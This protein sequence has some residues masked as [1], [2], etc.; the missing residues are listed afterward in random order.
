MPGQEAYDYVIVGADPAGSTL[1]G[2]LSDEKGIKLIVSEA[3]PG[4]RFL[5][6]ASYED[7]NA[8]LIDAG[9]SNAVVS[10]HAPT[11]CLVLSFLTA[12]SHG[13]LTNQCV[14]RHTD[15][16]FQ[17]N[18]FVSPDWLGSEPAALTTHGRVSVS[19]RL[20]DR[21]GTQGPQLYAVDV[22]LATTHSPII[23]IVLSPLGRG[24]DA[25]ALVF[26]LSG[27]LSG[28][29]PSR[30]S[31]SIVANPDGQL[32]IHST[33]SGTLQSS[34]SLPEAGA[35]WKDEGPILQSLTLPHPPGEPA[36]FYRVLSP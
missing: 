12:S 17:T 27:V 15:G 30:P 20:A 28:P 14:I 5:L 34:P 4:H 29:T 13:P 19:T 18:R 7:K 23:Q 2:Q 36:R 9:S 35:V 11:S 16:I 3:D 31:L 25:H 32:T 6:P 26:A 1:A 33:Q 10:L 21:I 24:T 8:V 22:P